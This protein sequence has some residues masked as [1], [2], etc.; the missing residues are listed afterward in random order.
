[1]TTSRCIVSVE[2]RLLLQGSFCLHELQ[3]GPSYPPVVMSTTPQGA[4]VLA[5]LCCPLVCPKQMSGWYIYSPSH[6]H[7]SHIIY[8]KGPYPYHTNTEPNACQEKSMRGQARLT[9]YHA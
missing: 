2:V 5:V 7:S 8:S 6:P 1:M 3:R 4:V 9:P